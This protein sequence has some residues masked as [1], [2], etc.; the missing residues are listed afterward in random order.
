MPSYAGDPRWTVARFN[1]KCKKCGAD[2]RKGE[3]IFYYPNAR[4]VF[5]GECAS[6]EAESF[7][8]AAADEASMYRGF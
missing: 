2:I 4:A 3:R 8:A 6:D 1:S 7:A 5:S